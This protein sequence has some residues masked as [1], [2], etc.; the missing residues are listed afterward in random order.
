MIFG[1]PEPQPL[2]TAD[3][4]EP[5]TLSLQQKIDMDLSE[6]RKLLA[7]V[8]AVTE[9]E[10][11]APIVTKALRMGKPN[12]NSTRP[13]PLKVIF[14]SPS[15]ALAVLRN[16]KHLPPEYGHISIYDDKTIRQQE[17]FKKQKA[18]L[19]QRKKNGETNL[20][21]RFVKGIPVIDQKPSSNPPK[22]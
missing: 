12:Q 11:K 21:I 16:K 2:T 1:I 8:A 13:R 17:Y 22:N 7:A 4:T 10:D 19:E 18:I 9:G 14:T 3:T 15:D 5:E 20:I 6:T